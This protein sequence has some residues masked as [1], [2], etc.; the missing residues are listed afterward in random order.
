M[1]IFEEALN[2]REETI[3]T[4]RDLHRHPELGL[5]EIR[6]SSIV[7]DTLR[8]LGMDVQTGVA[9]TGVVGLLRR[10]KESPVLLMRFDMDALPIQ[11][12][13]G[14]DYA[15][16]NPGKMHACGHDG[17]VAVGLSVA[18]L[19][20]AHKD[21]LEGTIKFVFQPGEEGA[22]GGQK[23][24]AEGVM[25]NPKPDF[26]LAM[27]VWNQNPLG[28]YGLNPGPTMAGAEIFFVKIKGVGGHGAAP[29]NTVDP[30]VAA[31]HIITAL[32]T[33]TSRN[34]NPLDSAVV[35]VGKLTAG[36]AFNIIPQEAYLEGTVRTFKPEV[37]EMVNQRL[38]E[39][40]EHTAR[41]MGC[42]A[43]IELIKVTYP[44]INHPQLTALISDVVRDVDPGAQVDPS[45]QTMGSE[46]FSF[47][48]QELPACFMMVGSANVKKGL[49]YDHHHPK[50]NFDEE[51]LPKAVGILAESAIRILK[52]G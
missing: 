46:D 4:R 21:V 47:M 40:I 20:A 24:V 10:K 7:A 3:A 18:K 12:D 42:E 25:E 31:A 2:L 33:I 8:S 27:H 22:G 11:E 9:E 45:F 19:L 15:S 35:T 6:T 43:E 5:E 48:M 51:C 30:L 44:V 36:S 29:H 37:T 13:T 38:T 52:Q 50:F 16:E 1:T 41:A 32:Q 39:I 26:S 23:M 28:W 17:H 34:V 49:K 14:V